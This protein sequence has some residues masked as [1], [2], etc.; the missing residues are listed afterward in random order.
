MQAA[1]AGL[2][3]VRVPLWPFT[4]GCARTLELFHPSATKYPSTLLD[5]CHLLF[6]PAR[7]LPWNSS[8]LNRRSVGHGRFDRDT[9]PLATT[10]RKP[11]VSHDSPHGDCGTLHLIRRQ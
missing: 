9:K 10:G 7:R 4:F 11:S 1:E 3:S 5:S 2:S 8:R 6:R